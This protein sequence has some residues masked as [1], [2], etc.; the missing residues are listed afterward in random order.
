M[1]SVRTILSVSVALTLVFLTAQPAPAQD[2]L[3]VDSSASG[4][5]DGTSWTDAY[6]HLQDAVD[7]VH[8]QT[9]ES[10]ILVAEGVYYPDADSDGD[11]SAD[12]QTEHFELAP[13]SSAYNLQLL[14]GYPAGGG[15][16]DPE[17]H[18]TVLSGDITQ[19]DA[20][21][22]NGVTETAADIAGDNSHQVVVMEN[23]ANL[24]TLL[25]GITIT[26]GQADGSYEEQSGA[27]L[28][29]EGSPTLRRVMFAGN[30]AEGS[31]GGQ[32][33]EPFSSPVN[34]L[35]VN[36]SFIGNEAQSGGA[37]YNNGNS[38]EVSPTL[39]NAVFSGN[40]AEQGGAVYNFASSGGMSSPIFINATFAGN[41]ANGDFATAGAMHNFGAG[42]DPVEPDL[43]NSVLWGNTAQTG[44][45]Q[46]YNDGS[47]T[48]LTV[49]HSLLEGGL[50]AISENGGSS[51]T[52]EGGNLNSDPQ[53][54]DADGP[55]S[56]PGTLDDDLRLQGPN[57]GGGP[58][59]ALDAGDGSALPPDSADID[60]DGDG[61]EDFPIDRFG[62]PR[63]QNAMGSFIVDMGVHESDGS[64]L[65]VELVSFDARSDGEEIHLSW[66]T[67]SETD[68]A[69]FEVQRTKEGHGQWHTVGR[70]EGAGTITES[71][72]YQFV[73]Q[74]LP[75]ADRF[76]Y[77]LKQ[78]DV[79]GTVHY[80]TPVSVRLGVTELTLK[81][82]SP[83]PVR[84][85][86][87]VRYA[88]PESEDRQEVQLHLYDTLGRTV[89]TLEYGTAGVG[90]QQQQ[91]DVSGLPSGTYFLRLSTETADRTRKLT[92]VQ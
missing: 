69:R 68:N 26:A 83:N 76:R 65:P 16:R 73:D 15:A 77:R 49:N 79:D 88:L 44:S 13:S 53:F 75:Y 92:I 31:G 70:V 78:V 56:T 30:H 46:I 27:G 1:T 57:S 82:L 19:D 74:N 12:D 4:A 34:P 14:G 2:T 61:T 36:V 33:N 47:G 85:Q 90:R 67:V 89:R 6:E 23:L 10:V 86:V 40:K 22:T 20:S 58:S 24:E 62:N 9:V 72:S 35:L 42:G 39:V 59:P 18:V 60:G 71:R 8:E 28:R 80:S 87:T 43:H 48:T 29:N 17:S 54:A 81:P 32:F 5:N 64:P 91:V 21:N 52:D 25:D 37:L 66:Q 63:V 50:S 84:Q 38:E 11:H 41:T 3:Y 45:D 51:T 55:D 7:E